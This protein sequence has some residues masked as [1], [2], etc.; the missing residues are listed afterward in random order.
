MSRAC[1]LKGCRP[2]FASLA[3][4]V[5]I[6][7]TLGG[8]REAGRIFA[9][10]G[11]RARPTVMHERERAAG[12][13]QEHPVARNPL[14]EAYFGELHLH[15][16]YSSD[17]YAFGTFVDPDQ[18]YRFAQ[19][20]PVKLTSGATVRLNDPLDFMAVTDHSEW[21]GEVEMSLDRNHPQYSSPWAEFL[22]TAWKNQ[23]T[24]DKLFN[25][26]FS[27]EKAGKRLEI[28]GPGGKYALQAAA[29]LW[30]KIVDTANRHNKPGRF[31]TFAG[32]EWTSTPGGAN[33]HR[34][35]IFRGSKVPERPISFFEASDPKDLWDW[36]E[37]AAGGFDNVLAIPHNSNFSNGL[38]F[39][40]KSLDGT[41]FTFAMGARRKMAEPLVEI[42]QLKGIS[43]TSLEF[44]P[45]DEFANFELAPAV[46]WGTDPN[47][48]RGEPRFNW[49]REGLKAGLLEGQRLGVNPFEYGFAGGTDSHDGLAGRVLE[50]NFAFVTRDSYV[51]WVAATLPFWQNSGGLTA[52]WAE[53]NTRDD[54]WLA[55]KRR[56]AYATSGTRMR[57]RF[58]GGWD[59]PVK[60]LRARNWVAGAY[61]HGV[62]MGAVL[63]RRP[64]AEAPRFI[65]WAMMAPDGAPLDRIQI[66]KGWA[67]NGRTFERV[68]DI[69]CSKGRVPDLRTHR[70]PV[71][72][73][74]V[75]LKDCSYTKNAGD[76][77]LG[78]VW[79]DPEFRA[80]EP[81]FYYL[82]VL[83]IPTC[84]WSTFRALRNRAPL[85]DNV[86]ATL[87]ERAWSSSIWYNPKQ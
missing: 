22:R 54:I 53:A 13:S 61:R 49:A 67:K 17:A 38:M 4:I 48:L 25:Q 60:A 44:A 32:F 24:S 47:A 45:N 12:Q 82:R 30:S 26:I 8:C 87:Q 28:A 35:I 18:A 66:V 16:Q 23:E 56:E 81:A 9:A 10:E 63:P 85:P 65:T 14:K 46:P 74:R 29:T 43:E 84:R 70:C 5:L 80:S 76:V 68:F 20:E 75:N 11:I 62:P 36:M 7:P 21:F 27:A 83:E 57:V 55:L 59:Y 6:V 2:R 34:N 37:H 33:L 50:R 69:T 86:P 19:G 78:A 73:G 79:R 15:T 51:P 77:T 1:K 52:V 64:G 72:A 58:F 31:T 40:P 71:G 3:A 42:V 39:Q 41:D